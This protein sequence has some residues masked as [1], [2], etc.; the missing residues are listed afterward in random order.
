MTA[1]DA[2]RMIKFIMEIDLMLILS[3]ASQSSLKFG[4]GRMRQAAGELQETLFARRRDRLCREIKY[5]LA[6]LRFETALIRHACICRKAGFN[7]NQPR[8]PAGSPEGGRWTATGIGGSPRDSTGMSPDDLGAGTSRERLADASSVLGSPVM[9]DATP[10]PIIPGAQYAQTRIEFKPSAWTG[11]SSI[12]DTTKRLAHT[13]AHVRDFI[14]YAPDLGPAIYGTAV[15]TAFGVSLR[16]QRIPGLEVEPTFGGA[17]YGAKGSVRPDAVLRDDGGDVIAIYD[18]KTG[19]RGIDPVRAARLRLA[20]GV[21]NDVPV[22]ELSVPYGVSR[23]S[24]IGTR[25]SSLIVTSSK[26]REIY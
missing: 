6:A 8:V 10:D 1:P 4:L 17:Y 16:L 15:H 11:F 9:S 2:S 20:I 13:L 7:P 12:D 21:G 23:K 22:I 26:K 3:S 19:K 18:V 24:A 5:E 25:L 14:N